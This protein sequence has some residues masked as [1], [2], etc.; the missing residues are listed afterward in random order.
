M[1]DELLPEE[2]PYSE[3]SPFGGITTVKTIETKGGDRPRVRIF[4]GNE[5]IEH[6]STVVNPDDNS[7][8]DYVYEINSTNPVGLGIYEGIAESLTVNETYYYRG[9]AENLGGASWSDRIE[10]F[11][12]ID[13]RFTKDTLDGLVLWLDASDVDGDGFEDSNLEGT[14]SLFGLINQLSQTSVPECGQPNPRIRHQ[15]FCSLPGVRFSTGQS[16]NI[17]SL[18]LNYGEVHVFMVAQGTGVG[19]GGSDGLV[20]WTLD[21][22]PGNR[23]GSYKSENNALQQLTIGY[24]PPIWF[25][26]IDW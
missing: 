12:A 16:Y 18:S 19:I 5:R 6:N 20:G 17:G 22:K 25:W 2:H 3:T 23:F 8:W 15:S 7:S 21:A 9:Y 11:K 14:H 1:V 13:T 10:T 26:A 4:W 24:D